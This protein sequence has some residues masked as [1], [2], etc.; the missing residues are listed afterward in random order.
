MARR[1]AA[2]A[3]LLLVLAAVACGS[4]DEGVEKPVRA[5]PRVQDT[6]LPIRTEIRTVAGLP[7]VVVRPRRHG[8]WPLVVWVDGPDAPPESYEGLLGEIAAAGHVV[9]APTMPGNAGAEAGVALPFQPDRVRQVI[10]AVTTGP[11]AI[12]AA[13]P[14]HVAV[15]GHGLGAMTALAVGFNSCCVDHRVDAVVAVA[16]GLTA[17]PGGSYNTGTIPVLLVHGARDDV[18]PYA[19]SGEALQEVGT[20][21][22]LL[23]VDRGDHDGYLRSAGVVH[24]A[25]RDAILAFLDATI[26][27]SPQAGLADLNFAGGRPGVL[28]TTRG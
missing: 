9:V 7:T 21:A 22:Y 28:L 2:A 11:Y 16:G 19:R 20:S 25:V 24:A 1:T 17:F 8:P 6:G 4:D 3:V 26:G 15:T 14:E 10:D 12:A 5:Q 18:V 13:D 23:T 27:G